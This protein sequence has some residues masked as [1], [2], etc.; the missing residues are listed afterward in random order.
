M[1][2]LATHVSTCAKR[3]VEASDISFPDFEILGVQEPTSITQTEKE[4]KALIEKC[5]KAYYDHLLDEAYRLMEKCEQCKE[6]AQGE[7]LLVIESALNT[8]KKLFETIQSEHSYM[9]KIL[10]QLKDDE[11]WTADSIGPNAKFH[12]KYIPNTEMVSL[13]LDL[14]V[15]VPLQT[16][17]TLINE[18]DLWSHWAP[19]MKKTCQVKRIHRSA[20]VYYLEMGL[21]YPLSN[22]EVHLYGF[23]INR[24]QENGS[25]LILAESVDNNEE[26]LQRHDVKKVKSSGTVNMDIHFAGFE[27][28]PI[29]GNRCRIAGVLN[30]NPKFSWLPASLLNMILKKAMQFIMDRLVSRA[31]KFKGSVWEKEM[32]KEE[33]KEFYQ[34]LSQIV[35]DYYKNHNQEPRTQ[36]SL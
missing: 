22:R 18:I 3:E 8:E 9:T 30:V 26:F 35:E 28:S 32:L 10:G 25:V 11:G 13:K 7:A 4:V 1:E 17:L 14:N 36:P 34:W 19:F 2:V 6:Q 5:K 21:P 20:A 24:L 23:G 15:D 33:K 29:D 31:K 27:L 16:M 12:Y